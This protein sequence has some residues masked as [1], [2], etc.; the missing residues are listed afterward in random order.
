MHSRGQRQPIRPQES[1]ESFGGR[2]KDLRY[3]LV[4]IESESRVDRETYDEAG[5]I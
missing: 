5:N 4:H 2:N 3:H 1:I